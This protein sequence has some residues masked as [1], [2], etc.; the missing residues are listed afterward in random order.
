VTFS[1]ES[2][3]FERAQYERFMAF[4]QRWFRNERGH[5]VAGFQ[6]FPTADEFETVFERN[7]RAWLHDREIEVTW[8]RG[9]PYRG[10]EPFDL[11]HAPIFFGR[12]RE[13]E[14]ARARLIASAAA[15]KPFLLIIGAS[16]A[17]KSS[18]ARVSP[19]SAG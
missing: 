18:L 7:L 5:F 9:S 17:G 10:L 1:A 4:W 14:R 13:V 8:T 2:L 15:G 3:E 6:S 16:G 12:R 11:E 19:S